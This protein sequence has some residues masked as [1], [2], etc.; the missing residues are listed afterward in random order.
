MSSSANL[1]KQGF[2]LKK[3]LFARY[4]NKYHVV[5]TDDGLLKYKKQRK[6]KWKYINLQEE[7]IVIIEDKK[8]NRQFKIVMAKKKLNFRAETAVER[9]NWVK[10]IRETSENKY[11]GR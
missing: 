1:L 4:N 9:E 10:I 8:S 3:G 6:Q 2:L 7:S 5:L 11:I